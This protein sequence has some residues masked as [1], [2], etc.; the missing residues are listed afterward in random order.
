MEAKQE[1]KRG[2][3]AKQETKQEAKRGDVAKQEAKRDEED[4]SG[5]EVGVNELEDEFEL[6]GFVS[7]SIEAVKDVIHSINDHLFGYGPPYEYDIDYAVEGTLTDECSK[8]KASCSPLKVHRLLNMRMDP[9]IPDPDDLYLYPLHWCA[10]HCHYYVTVMLLRAKANVNVTNELGQTPLTYCVLQIVTP[11]KRH[12]QLSI[13][14]MLVNHYTDIE[15]RDKAGYTCL[16]YAVMNNDLELT[17]F[18][19]SKG[20]KV[21]RD[22]HTLV[23]ERKPLLKLAEKGDPRI[24]KAILLRLEKEEKQFSEYLTKREADIKELEDEQRRHKLFKKLEKMKERKA[25]MELE[26]EEKK[27]V[28]LAKHQ[29][30]IYIEKE[31]RRDAVMRKKTQDV[32]AMQV[33]GHWIKEGKYWLYSSENKRSTQATMYADAKELMHKLHDNHDHKL[34]DD[35]WSKITNHNSN[36]MVQKD[37]ARMFVED[38]DGN[39][40]SESTPSSSPT[41]SP[42]KNQL[43]CAAEL[44]GVDVN[45]L[46][47]AL[48]EL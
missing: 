15:V 11:D 33:R 19:L 35:R 9:N 34:F 20:A 45:D 13:V 38:G 17:M 4:D 29:R 47:D 44:E 27:R 16:D 26:L 32:A 6:Q 7:R 23:A 14:K 10:K 37:R 25:A 2:G 22:N 30:Q 12:D 28:E 31:Q 36:L 46:L 48:D 41:S 39:T 3:V 42:D 40:S 24:F 43:I 8:G 21:R 5:D 18:I 1:A